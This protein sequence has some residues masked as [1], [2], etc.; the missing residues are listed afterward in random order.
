METLQTLV[1]KELRAP[2]ALF[3]FPPPSEALLRHPK[4]IPIPKAAREGN[5]IYGSVV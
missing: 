2:D 4:A 3:P 5:L 1:L